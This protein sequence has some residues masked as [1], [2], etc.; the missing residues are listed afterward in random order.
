MFRDRGCNQKWPRDGILRVWKRRGCSLDR[1]FDRIF[2]KIT[3]KK[4]GPMG[5]S[6]DPHI[7]P[8]SWLRPCEMI[9]QGVNNFVL[10]V[11]RRGVFNMPQHWHWGQGITNLTPYS[12]K[13]NKAL[14]QEQALS[15]TVA[16]V[17][18]V[19]F[20]NAFVSLKQKWSDWLSLWILNQALL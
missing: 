5:M 8:P 9:R 20:D 2:I 11:P 7:P 6:S 19:L 14:S 10:L 1:H 4:N 15:L 16:Y 13:S 3:K 17:I 12:T 18:L